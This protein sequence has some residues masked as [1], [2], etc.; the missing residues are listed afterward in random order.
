MAGICINRHMNITYIENGPCPLCE[1]INERDKLKSELKS[2]RVEL[3]D[4]IAI[5]DC[6][7][8]DSKCENPKGKK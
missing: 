6:C 4:Q 8:D 5:I 3:K 7:L 2:I 1:V